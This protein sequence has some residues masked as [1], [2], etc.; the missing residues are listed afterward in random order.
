MLF[1]SP[2]YDK[3]PGVI[4]TISGYMGGKT[5]NPTYEA[6]VSG[7]TGHAEVVQVQYDPSKVSYER[8]LEVFWRNIDPTDGH[9]QFCDKGSQYRSA[10][11]FH[12]EEQRK[13]ALASKASLDQKKPFKD[14]IVTEITA[15]GEFYSAEGYHQ[16]YLRKNPGGYSCHFMRD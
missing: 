1:R 10:V 8:L 16:D 13:A 6:V 14:P 4:S 15:A 11:F 9:G 2:P 12:N 5:K 3:L 7:A